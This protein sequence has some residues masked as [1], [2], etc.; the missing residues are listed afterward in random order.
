MLFSSSSFFDRFSAF[1]CVWILQIFKS[2]QKYCSFHNQYDQFCKRLRI[3]CGPAPGISSWSITDALISPTTPAELTRLYFLRPESNRPL[4]SRIE[5]LYSA[6]KT[7][8]I[9][10]AVRALRP[11]SVPAAQSEHDKK[12]RKRL[13]IIIISPYRDSVNREYWLTKARK[14]GL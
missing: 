3:T 5:R 8:H 13:Y 9:F 7:E 14:N 6:S 10:V 11:G 2:R 1:F 4:K 12:S